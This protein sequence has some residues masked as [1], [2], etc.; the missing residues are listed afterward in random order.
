MHCQEPAPIYDLALL[1][2]DSEDSGWTEAD[3]A[4]P[5]LARYI[6]ELLQSK[7]E[8]LQDYF[9][10]HID[11]VRFIKSNISLSSRLQSCSYLSVQ[12]WW[13]TNTIQWHVKLFNYF[14]FKRKTYIS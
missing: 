4:K 9:S 2:L 5:D 12:Y 11:E 7:T 10:V 13:F 1:A 3:G 6:I 14:S 8:M